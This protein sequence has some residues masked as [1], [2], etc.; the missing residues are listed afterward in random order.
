MAAKYSPES[1]FDP[2]KYQDWK[3]KTIKITTDNLM[4]YTISRPAISLSRRR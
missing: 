3:G 4:G 2:D 1:G